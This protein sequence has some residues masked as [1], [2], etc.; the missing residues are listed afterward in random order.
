M[1]KEPSKI[2]ALG[3]VAKAVWFSLTFLAAGSQ[4]IVTVG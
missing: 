1:V 4:F 2:T 3:L